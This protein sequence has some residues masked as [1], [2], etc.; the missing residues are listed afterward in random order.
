MSSIL[1]VSQ[2][3]TDLQQQ[4]LNKKKKKKK[5][6][7]VGNL[8]RIDD[9]AVSGAEEEEERIFVSKQKELEL[10]LVISLL[11]CEKSE[12]EVVSVGSVPSR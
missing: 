1:N 12:A 5:K 2:C 7:T 8:P 11:L 4:H 10:L 6:K 9:I 3:Y